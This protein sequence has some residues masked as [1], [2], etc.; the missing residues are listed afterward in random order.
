MTSATANHATRRDFLMIATGAAGVVGAG[1]VVWPLIS[2]LGPDA[3]TI[4]A[5]APVDLDLAPISEGQ[6]VK[7]FWRGRLIFVR[8][9][10]KKEIDEA[11][12][13]D[14]ASLIDPM[15]DSARVK[16]GSTTPPGVCA[17]VRRR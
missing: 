13:V 4:A 1:A 3:V 8:N 16:E 15:A 5:G 6:I 12:N 11:A 7:L 17:G 10:S 14:M 2:S 9:R